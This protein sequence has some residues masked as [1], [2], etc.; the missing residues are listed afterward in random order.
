MTLLVNTFGWDPY[1]FRVAVTEILSDDKKSV[2]G[3]AVADPVSFQWIAPLAVIVNVGVG[4]LVS[5]LTGGAKPAATLLANTD[6]EK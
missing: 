1:Q 2:I 4:S 6:S 3:H 5:L